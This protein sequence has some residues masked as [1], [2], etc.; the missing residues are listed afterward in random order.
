MEQGSQTRRVAWVGSIRAWRREKERKE[1]GDEA[2]PRDVISGGQLY[3]FPVTASFM[4]LS[5]FLAFKYLPNEYLSL[6]LTGGSSFLGVCGVGNVVLPVLVKQWPAWKKKTIGWQPVN[7]EVLELI[8]IVMASPIGI[9]YFRKKHFLANNILGTALAY[10][11]VEMLG[12]EDYKSGAILLAGL[13]FYD[14]FWV[15]FS[16][17][18]F[19]ANV[20]V[21]V[22]KKFEGPIKLIFPQF[23]GAGQDKQSMLG[24]GDIVIPGIFIALMFRFDEHIQPSDGSL[25][26]RKKP[27]F[28]SV[29]DDASCFLFNQRDLLMFV[30]MIFRGPNVQILVSYF[31]GLALTYVVMAVFNHA[32]PALLYLVPACLLSSIGCALIRGEARSLLDYSEAEPDKVDSDVKTK[33]E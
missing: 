9:W 30:I 2:E 12:L 20:M 4:L 27:Y 23:P 29:R 18:V 14:I 24:L 16:K 8:S 26:L 31:G 33:E 6:L 5:L 22:A 32:Q 15:F 7:I 10:T 3:R 21:T 13:F 1:S 25:E 19:G 28:W 11:A 17:D